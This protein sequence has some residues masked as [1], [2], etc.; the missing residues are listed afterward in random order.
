LHIR[1]LI[2]EQQG[3]SS[4]ALAEFREAV[5]SADQWRRGALPGDATSTSTVVLLNDVY[6]D[7]ALL[8]ADQSLKRH[9]PALGREA[10]EVL[11]ENRAASLR[12]QLTASFGRAL[13][14]PPRYFE[15]LSQLQAAQAG[16]TL[17]EDNRQ[18]RLK[19][20][21][22]RLELSDLGNS[23]GIASPNLASQGE[24]KAHKNSLRNIQ[25]RLTHNEALL[26]F[27]L[28]KNESFVWVVTGDE[29]QLYKLGPENEIK[30]K[31]VDFTDA[32]RHGSASAGPG[33]RLSQTLFQQ[34]DPKIWQKR[35]WLVAGDGALLDGV[36]FSDLPDLSSP[37]ANQVLMA[38]HDVRFLPSE[39]LL[40]EPDTPSPNRIFVGVADPI[41]NTADS[42]RPRAT[43]LIAARATREAVALARP[44]AVSGKYALP[45]V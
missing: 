5:H 38:S 34:L 35:Q 10:W 18:E 32:V 3:H 13:K 8:A 7:F 44:P 29:V 31:A 45:P 16:V 33:Q 42:R 43:R 30:S 41:Y 1:A 37:N 39:L 9:D 24:K 36:P 6:R 15:L 19:L 23:I 11:A 27:C 28:G 17:G 20:N 25:A 4:E 26:S 2:L 22:I 12:E 40:L 21:R 14:L